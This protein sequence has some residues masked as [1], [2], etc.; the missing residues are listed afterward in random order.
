MHGPGAHHRMACEIPLAC[1][2]CT[3]SG[4]PWWGGIW[5]TVGE[6]RGSLVSY[7][8]QAVHCTGSWFCLRPVWCWCGCAPG[9]CCYPLQHGMVSVQEHRMPV[10]LAD[11]LFPG[12][13]DTPAPDTAVY[14]SHTYTHHECSHTPLSFL[15]SLTLSHSLL[16]YWPPCSRLPI[17]K[18]RSCYSLS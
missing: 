2:H 4:I 7:G 10:M 15:Y 3:W 6:W 8:W 12:E 11:T 16:S 14:Y 1:T 13:P 5:L 9:L 18:P 17:F